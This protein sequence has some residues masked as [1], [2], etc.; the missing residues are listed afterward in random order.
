MSGLNNAYILSI[1]VPCYNCEKTLD[2]TV[3]SL[4]RQELT[5]SIGYSEY[6][7]VLVD[8]G[9]KDLTPEI[10]DKY[11]QEYSIVRAVHKSNGGLVSAWKTG[12][13]N[14]GGEYI[15][16][17]DADDYIDKDFINTVLKT[18][19]SYK[20]DVIA[21]GMI[22]EYDNGEVEK[23]DILLKSGFYDRPKINAEILPILLSNGDMESDLI[24]SSRCNKVFKK[25]LLERIMNDVSDTLSMGEDDVTS[26]AAALNMCSIYS[27]NGYFPYHYVRNSQS[28]IGAYDDKIFSKI[29]LLYE[30]LKAVSQKYEYLHTDQVEKRILALLF[31]YIKKEICKYP[32]NRKL[33]FDRLKRIHNSDTFNQCFSES[34]IRNYSLTKKLFA[35]MFYK[36]LYGFL[37]VVV[38]TFELIRGRNV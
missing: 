11:E 17:C 18:I 32:G 37:Y 24:M 15:A 4:V 5:E 26:F 6:Q 8:D 38:K 25:V 29:D 28:M 13:R 23:N 3:E 27:I 34:T 31:I 7:V 10:C 35:F 12:V 22:T 33:L 21:F 20:P 9:S 36:E 2:K 16:F 1:V 30:S 14:A 19:N